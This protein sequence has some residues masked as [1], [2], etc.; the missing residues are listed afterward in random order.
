MTYVCLSI[1][2]TVVARLAVVALRFGSASLHLHSAVADLLAFQQ[3][4][5]VSSH[6]LRTFVPLPRQSADAEAPIRR[7]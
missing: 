3:A 5:D 1:C 6:T 2:S 4:L 7:H